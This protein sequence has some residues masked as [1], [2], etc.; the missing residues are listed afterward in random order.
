M[1]IKSANSRLEQCPVRLEWFS[2]RQNDT[3]TTSGL[4]SFPL[5]VTLAILLQTIH[6]GIRKVI[7]ERC[8]RPARDLLLAHDIRDWWQESQ[9]DIIIENGSTV[10]RMPN[11]EERAKVDLD[12]LVDI[13][14]YSRLEVASESKIGSVDS[15]KLLRSD[16]RVEVPL[17]RINKVDLPNENVELLSACV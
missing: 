4:P 17:E 7:Q 3:T 12:L 8:K 9:A 2:I 5:E 6:F 16:F 11:E 10:E 14:S 1:I 13:M 15:G